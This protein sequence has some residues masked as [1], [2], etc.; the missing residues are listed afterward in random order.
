M[1]DESLKPEVNIMSDANVVG[2]VLLNH[3]EGQA[4]LREGGGMTCERG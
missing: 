2:Y 4:W 3:I 1:S